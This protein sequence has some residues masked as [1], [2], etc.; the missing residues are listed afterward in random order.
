MPF[1]EKLSHFLTTD[2]AIATLH[3]YSTTRGKKELPAGTPPL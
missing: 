3:M 2:G 1:Y